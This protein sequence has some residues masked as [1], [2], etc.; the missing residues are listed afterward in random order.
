[1]TSK[2][3]KIALAVS[4][5]LNLFAVAG[6]VTYVVNRDR[7][8]RRIEDQRRPGREGPLAEVLADLDPA[9]RQR[10]RTSLRES[11][12]AARPDFEA[13]RAA[14]R[15]AIDV[16]G[17][18]ALDAARV[19]SLLEQSRAAEM[20]GRTRLEKGAVAV[21]ATLTPEERKALAPILQRK[22]AARR[23]AAHGPD[24]RQPDDRAPR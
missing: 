21:L 12:L 5:A 19:E 2:S 15:E 1:M 4:V 23:A 18:P 11:A 7:I 16:A 10:V 9:V 13:A 24:H 22:G 6:G 20:R 3:L 8:E 14:R 17:Q